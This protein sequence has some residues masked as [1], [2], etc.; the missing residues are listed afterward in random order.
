MAGGPRVDEVGMAPVGT[1]TSSLP[2]T[3]R[4]PFDPRLVFGLL[5]VIVC[6]LAYV[7]LALEEG[8]WLLFGEVIHEGGERN[9]IETFF[10]YEHALRELALDGLLGLALGW[11]VAALAPGRRRSRR[12]LGIAGMVAAGSIVLITLGT[13]REAGVE[14]ALEELAQVHTRPGAILEWGSH[15]QYHLLSRLALILLGHAMLMPLAG[16][17][18]RGRVLRALRRSLVA[19]VAL[20][21]IFL[22]RLESFIDP[23][24]L[25][26]QARELATHALTTLPLAL[27]VALPDGL[28]WDWHGLRRPCFWVGFG[29]AGV[30]A[31]WLGVGALLG[32]AAAE[33]QSP[34]WTRVLGGHVFEHGLGYLLVPALA[35]VVRGL[36]VRRLTP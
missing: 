5:P 31:L 24:Y 6:I 3:R 13:I 35:V 14:G 16:A 22:P 10:F 32:G 36:T 2:R 20:S 7:A 34:S 25:G 21:V 19:F 11:G 28:T 30:I 15:W 4:D 18:A 12:T 8:K 9:L 23:L 17:E 27:F 33:T 26:H 1:S 29:L